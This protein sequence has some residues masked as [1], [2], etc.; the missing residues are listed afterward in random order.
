L[1]TDFPAPFAIGGS[2]VFLTL[3]LIVGIAMAVVAVPGFSAAQV[4]A[5][6]SFQ[7]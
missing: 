2:Q 1:T 7:E 4:P 3:L 6:A 5:S